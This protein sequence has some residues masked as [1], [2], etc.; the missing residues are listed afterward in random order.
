ME[1]I[2]TVLSMT[3]LLMRDLISVLSSGY[4]SGGSKPIGESCHS[5]V[6]C[7]PR[8][9][10]ASRAVAELSSEPLLLASLIRD[11]FSINVYILF[12]DAIAGQC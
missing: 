10:R 7:K 1:V 3:L 5:E 6:K 8:G 11:R 4:V 12:H 9:C 2:R